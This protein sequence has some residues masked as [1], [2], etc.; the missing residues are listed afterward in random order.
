V[1]IQHEF[2]EAELNHVLASFVRQISACLGARCRSVILHGAV[3]FDDLAPGYGDLDFAV[4]VDDRLSGVDCREL[5]S[6]RAPFRDGTHGVY[7]AMLEG[8]F[9]PDD[10]LR[11]RNMGKAVWWG[12]SGERLWDRNKLGWF[13]HQVIRD[14]GIVIHGDDVREQ[15]E[16]PSPE[17]LTQE[18]RENCRT[19]RE[20]GRGGSLHSV[21]WLLT[22]ARLL[23]W[24][25]EG[26]LSSKTEAA[27][28]GAENARGAWR[29]LLPRAKALRLRPD[30]GERSE[31][32]SWLNGLEAAIAEAAQ[33]LEE[34]LT[35]ARA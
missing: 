8:A 20:H 7:G 29:S 12:T 14:R 3:V 2:A 34:R 11:P 19:M 31:I 10:L 32:Q 18:I 26:R 28:W 9:L 15:F 13:C 1:T 4:V 17:D 6:A 30:L 35:P 33:E 16:A 23:L 22:A 24:L 21:D 27:E 5:I 25:D